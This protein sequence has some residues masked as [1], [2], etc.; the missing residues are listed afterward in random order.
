MSEHQEDLIKD[1]GLIF[2]KLYRIERKNKWPD[3]I[4]FNVTFPNIW[5]SQKEK[6]TEIMYFV[7]GIFPKL[8]FK[9]IKS[10]QSSAFKLSYTE[11]R[12]NSKYQFFS[13]GIDSTVLLMHLSE[14][15]SSRIPVFVDTKGTISGPINR[16]IQNQE[17]KLHVI[18]IRYQKKSNSSKSPYA[19][20]LRTPLFV[21]AFTLLYHPNKTDLAIAE[22]GPTAINPACSASQKPTWATHPY[23]LKL[24]STLI[25]DVFNWDFSISLP[26]LNFTKPELI[27]SLDKSK[28]KSLLEYTNSCFSA[29]RYFRK[30]S[31]NGCGICFSC[32]IRKIA[33]AACG[34]VL[35]GNYQ[36]KALLSMKRDQKLK[37][38]NIE[39]LISYWFRIIKDKFPNYAGFQF[40]IRKCNYIFPNLD[41]EELIRRDAKQMLYGLYQL[42][43]TQKREKSFNIKLFNEYS[44][45]Y[46]VKKKDYSDFGEELQA[47]SDRVSQ[48]LKKVSLFQV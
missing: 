10:H 2:S 31:P 43:K 19:P 29:S 32:I 35:S 46:N 37:N 16:L 45:I 42:S 38:V 9:K 44:H 27:K 28:G 25:R 17:E 18:R 33:A 30:R 24:M 5:N 34:F 12:K 41:I 20:Q 6:L 4:R 48:S 36:K 1:I 8:E 15:K 26:F 14:L 13:A 21:S 3:P 40:P 39:S 23:V 7:T 11:E 22:N 47:N